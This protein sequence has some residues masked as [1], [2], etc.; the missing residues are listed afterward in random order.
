MGL[1]QHQPLS[2]TAVISERALT[3]S[4]TALVHRNFLNLWAKATP[5]M[6]LKETVLRCYFTRWLG[7]KTVSCFTSSPT[8]KISNASSALIRKEI[9]WTPP[10]Y[11]RI[12][13]KAGFLCFKVSCNCKTKVAVYSWSKRYFPNSKFW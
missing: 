7:K 5:L 8:L 4:L 10:K 1:S 6:K 3:Q 9:Q 13:W 11:N 12:S 2:P